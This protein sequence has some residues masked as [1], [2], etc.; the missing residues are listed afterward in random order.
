M[1]AELARGMLRRKIP[2]L[3]QALRGR[4]RDDHALLL[5]LCL[6]HIAYLAGA[7]A[8]LGESI[9]TLFA[10]QV[11]EA[12]VPFAGARDHLTTI[13]GVGQRA[14]ECILAEIGTDMTRFRTAAHRAA[15]I[16]F[17]AV[18]APV[19]SSVRRAQHGARAHRRPLRRRAR[20]VREDCPRTCQE[21]QRA[22]ATALRGP[23]AVRQCRWDEQT[24]PA[25]EAVEMRESPELRAMMENLYA[26]MA[27]GEVAWLSEA[28]SADEATLAIGTD[29]AEWWEGGRR[30]REMWAA[31]LAAGLGGA[32]F[33]PTRL[34]A[35]EEGDVGWAADEPR[36]LLPGSTPATVRLTAVFRREEGTW[37]IVQSHASIGVP[38]PESIGLDL[39]T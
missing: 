24:E 19:L 29:P 31:Q 4:F 6:E 39:P 38:N 22:D 21:H 33:E 11:S 13:T 35:Y 1:L 30:V 37:R 20:A 28:V 25:P 12:G 36:M 5:G 3:R 27:S 10:T 32:V 14:A 15:W 17:T 18:P 8:Q 7:I 34:R 2:A 9:D 26:A 16:L 23:P